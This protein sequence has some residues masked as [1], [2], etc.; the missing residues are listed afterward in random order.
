MTFPVSSQSGNDQEYHLKICQ[1]LCNLTSSHERNSYIYQVRKLAWPTIHLKHW[2]VEDIES[3]NY[4]AW[5]LEKGVPMEEI[6]DSIRV[7][8][9][10]M[11]STL[12]NGTRKQKRWFLN[13]STLV[14]SE[15][16][17]QKKSTFKRLANPDSIFILIRS[18][19][20][21]V[22]RTAGWFELTLIARYGRWSLRLYP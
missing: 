19:S 2:T 4:A 16:N 21:S 8:S 7:I 1:S 5:N 10:T 3:L 9:V 17:Y 15:S 13:R 11:P 12:C 18:W 20:K 14:D 22:R 6:K